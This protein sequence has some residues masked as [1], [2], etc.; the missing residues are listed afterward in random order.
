MSAEQDI[1]E[2]QEQIAPPPF[3]VLRRL[4]RYTRPYVGGMALTFVLI[5]C[6]TA[7]FNYPPVILRNAID[8]WIDA[9][10]LPESERMA[11]L[12]RL[13]VLYLVLSA[14]GCAVRYGQGL[15]TA[16]TGQRIVRDIRKDVF[17]K[18]VEM[19]R[20]F[21]DRTPVG[22][23]MTRVTSD[24]DVIQ[25]F[26]SEGVAGSLA[27]LFMF[28]GVVGFM[29][30]LSPLM[31]GC[32][33]TVIPVMVVL[34][35]FANGKLRRANRDI[36]HAQAAMNA[37]T[38]ESL[39]GMTTIQLFNR[40]EGARALFNEYNE[41]MKNACFREVRWFS[42]YFPVLE[43]AQAL[44]TVLILAAGGWMILSGKGHITLGGL[45]AFLTYIRE[46]FRPLD[47]LS[48]RIGNLQQAL[49]S[50][51]RIFGLMDRD[52][53]IHDPAEPVHA[54]CIR[55]HLR[56]DR[57]WFAYR[58]ENWVLKD[59]SFEVQPG[60]SIAIVGATGSGKTTIINLL[61][62]F[63][64]V[65]KGAVCIDGHDVRAYQK[66]DIRRHM[67]IVTQDPFLFSS[68][69]ADNISLKDP[70]ITRERI[71]ETARYVNAH[72]FIS[73]LPNGYDTMLNERGAGLSAGQKQLLALARALAQNRDALLILDEATANVD[74]ATEQ[75]IQDAL[76]RVMQNRTS[77]I[78]AHRLSTIRHVNRIIVL[79]QGRITASGTHQ[80]LIRQDGYYRRLYEYLS[81]TE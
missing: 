8:R 16:W 47:S 58:G 24:V 57:V 81:I 63:Y 29:V 65:Q 4:L 2:D 23:I 72:P 28:L 66:K 1:H 33:F 70:S 36:R 49:V 75:L 13:G 50:C 54:P 41:T 26:V 20:E 59:V 37:N 74:S 67:G 68:S 43:L 30:Y 44:S 71:E 27:D 3:S 69:I 52:E 48:N 38:Q 62:R 10:G 5:L 21:Y 79:Y 53:I 40:E 35:A 73:A 31:T 56:L 32:L 15:L 80:E 14:A 76:S 39:A 55:G 22:R 78:I 11:G 77:I 18:A 34:F 61:A 46:F 12:I 19:P 64:D 9:A 60:E 7:L 42:F 25:H 45:V 51:E 6:M 17:N